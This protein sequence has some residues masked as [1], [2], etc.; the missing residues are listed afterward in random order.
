MSKLLE[1]HQMASF[2]ERGKDGQPS[3]ADQE[4]AEVDATQL[5]QSA[6]EELR[7]RYLTNKKGSPNYISL[8]EI[9]QQLLALGVDSVE[10]AKKLGIRFNTVIYLRGWISLHEFITL[11]LAAEIPVEEESVSTPTPTPVV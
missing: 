1:R 2:L 8:I 10:T 11:A 3:S 7:I 5:L 9:K 6:V 4:E